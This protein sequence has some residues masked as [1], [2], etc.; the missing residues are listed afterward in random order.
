MTPGLWLLSTPENAAVNPAR[1]ENERFDFALARSLARLLLA[2][3][4]HSTAKPHQRASAGPPVVRLPLGE[5]L[6]RFDGF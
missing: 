5:S 1:P 4:E 2:S 6:V 3:H